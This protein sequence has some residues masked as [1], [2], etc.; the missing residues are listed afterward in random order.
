M[1]DIWTNADVQTLMQMSA[2][3][4]DE[5]LRT[6]AAEEHDIFTSPFVRRSPNHVMVYLTHTHTHI[7]HAAHK[8]RSAR[9]EEGRMTAA[10]KQRVNKVVMQNG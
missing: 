10:N 4:Q 8:C 6:T 1:D 3:H 5:T 9:T 2:A 7:T